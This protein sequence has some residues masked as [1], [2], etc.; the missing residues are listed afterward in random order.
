MTKRKVH[1][2]HRGDSSVVRAYE[3]FQEQMEAGN[4]RCVTF[5]YE[6]EAG[7]ETHTGFADDQGGWE[8][9]GA[10]SGLINTIHN[11]WGNDR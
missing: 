6:G 3:L 2:I 5:L 1:S 8:L 9:V 11:E 7:L 4:I 10:L